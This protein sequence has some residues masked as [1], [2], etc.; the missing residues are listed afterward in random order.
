GTGNNKGYRSNH[1]EVK[2]L[3]IP[4]SQCNEKRE[5]KLSSMVDF[6]WCGKLPQKFFI[7]LF[8]KVKV[9]YCLE[10]CV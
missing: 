3:Q 6:G 1:R 2:L 4:P 5:R 8:Q 9:Q 7:R 10:V